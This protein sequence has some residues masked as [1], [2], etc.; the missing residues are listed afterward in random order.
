MDKIKKL[1]E[2]EPAPKKESLGE[3]SEKDK[4]IRLKDLVM[5]SAKK[6]IKL[7]NKK[8]KIEVDPEV[9]IGIASSGGD[10]GKGNLH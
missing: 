9:S 1:G 8:T 2:T 4:K 5:K 10:T 3:E 6:K 7:D